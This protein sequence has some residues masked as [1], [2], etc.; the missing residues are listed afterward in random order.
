MTQQELES[1]CQV[2]GSLYDRGYAFGS[3][4]N[5]SIRAGDKVYVTP[6]GRS[7][8]GLATSEI[9]CLDLE[10]KSFNENRPSKESPFHLAIYRTRSDAQAIVH[11]HS[12]YSVALSCLKELNPES[13]LQAITPYYIMRVTPLAVLPYFPPGSNALGQAVGEASQ[14][15]NCM[16]LRNHGLITL[17]R[18][19]SEAVDRAEELEQT[20]RLT[21]LLKGEQIRYLTEQEVAELQRLFA[22]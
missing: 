16:L 3:T 4:G 9:A 14:I 11:L 22:G 12:T 2:A 8:K 1:L 13:P 6:T 18:T 20:A 21:F 19:L 7:L 10:G 15:H 17:G 5:L